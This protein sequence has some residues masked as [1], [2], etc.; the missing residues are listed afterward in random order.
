M[1]NIWVQIVYTF[2]DLHIE[3]SVTPSG[4]YFQACK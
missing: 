4:C 1:I 3:T 2:R